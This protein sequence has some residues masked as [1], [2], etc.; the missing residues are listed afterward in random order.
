MREINTNNE[1]VLTPGTTLVF[2]GDS[3]TSRR[4]PPSLDTW[5]LLQLMNWDRT[6]ADE[7]SRVLFC[8]H[9][10]LNLTF[11]NAAVGGSSCRNVR[12]RQEAF[13]LPHNPALVLMT[14]GANDNAQRIPLDEFRAAMSDYARRLGDHCGGKVLFVGGFHH[15]RPEDGPEP[16]LPDYYSVLGEVASAHGGFYLDVGI[17]LKAK[18][19]ALLA[20]SDCHII[21]SDGNH[22]N[23]LGNMIV[24]GEV[25]R[26][27]IG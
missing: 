16:T 4:T 20:Q 22:L 23:A 11:H 9:P 8:W 14:I 17:G 27:L 18:S 25:Y 24:A 1:C 12:D 13:V 10:E 15:V 26:F 7:L 2:D 19:D 3:M 5:P 6:W 21:N